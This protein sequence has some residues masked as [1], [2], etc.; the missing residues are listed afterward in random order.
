MTA[1]ATRARAALSMTGGRAAVDALRADYERSPER[2]RLTALIL[3]M[4]TTGSPEDIAFLLGQVRGPFVGLGFWPGTT[5]AA[6][7]LGLLRAASTRDSLQAL[8]RQNG[9]RGFSGRAVLWAIAAFGRPQCADSARG[10]IT[11]DLV[12]IVVACEPQALW[13]TARYSDSTASGVWSHAGGSWQLT[14]RT[15]VDTVGAPRL[16]TSVTVHPGER[17]AEVRLRTF[18]GRLCGEV[19]TYRLML[20]EGRWRVTSAVLIAVA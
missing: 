7:Q 4:G 1:T 15:A 9:E 20:Q 5:H 16:F 3:A 12:R 11:R 17:Y 6:T 19:W 18:C 8:L 2:Q 13:P 10:E 14:P